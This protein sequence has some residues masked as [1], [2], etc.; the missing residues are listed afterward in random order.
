[1][2]FQ[3]E[4]ALQIYIDESLD[5]LADFEHDL[6]LMEQ[7]GSELD[8][9]IINKVF[10]GAHSIKGGA[11]LL[12]FKNIK[13]LA[14]K[15]ENLLGMI[16]DHAVE[17]HSAIINVLLQAAD[18]LKDL[19]EDS[20]H[21]DDKDISNHL[22]ALIAFCEVQPS[23][24]TLT[25]QT[26]HRSP[27]QPKLQIPGKE[28]TGKDTETIR[29]YIDESL[30]HLDEI[31]SDILT[32]EQAGADIDEDLVNKVF[33][34]AHSIK[35]GAGFLGF[36]NIKK[37]AHKIESLLG[38][39]RSRELAVNAEIINALLKG[40][41]SLRNLINNITASDDIDI[42]LELQTLSVFNTEDRQTAAQPG[43]PDLQHQ[44]PV[45]TTDREEESAPQQNGM[46]VAPSA[47]TLRV[48][49]RL[50]DSLMTLAGEL[51]LSRN[52]LLQATV[53]GDVQHIDTIGQNINMI[54]SEL[55]EAIMHTRLQPIGNIF[56]KFPRL[57][58]DLAKEVDK[59]VQLILA[60]ED[61]ELDKTII[62][63][64]SD[65]LTHLV[66]NSIDHGIEPPDERRAKNKPAKGT[67]ILSA[68]HEAG[69]V[70]LQIK[71]DGQGLNGEAFVQKAIDTGLLRSDQARA[72]SAKE[73][74]NLILQPGFSMAKTVTD[75]SG[76]GVGMDVVK[77]N[78]EKLGGQI[79]INSK[80]GKGTTINI[81][82]PL[83][84]AIIS[85]QLIRNN[86]ERYAIPQVNLVELLRIPANQ[87]KNRIERVGSADVVR[88]RDH[89][90]PLVRLTAV[91]GTDDLYFDPE[92]C[93][94]KRNRRTKL[95]DRRSKT[96]PLF[97]T[98]HDSQAE[99]GVINH[100]KR[101]RSDRRIHAASALNI[102]IVSNG[103]MKYGL[104]VDQLL[105]SEEIVVKPLGQHLK[106]CTIY[107]GATILGDGRISLILDVANIAVAAGLT[108][109]D[110]SDRAHEITR[111]TASDAIA[112]RERQALLV[113]R[114]NTEE[115]FAVPLN[116]V[117][118]IEKIKKSQIEEIGGKRV[119]QYRG[120]TLMLFSIDQAVQVRPIADQEDLLVLIFSLAGH[121]VGLLA[122]GPVNS[123]EL[124]FDIDDRTH[125]Q[126]GVMGSTLIDGRIT[127][128]INIYDIFQSLNPDWFEKRSA[129]T[130]PDGKGITI[131][132]VEDSNFFRNQVKG[133]LAAENYKVLEA[134]DGLVA[135]DLLAKHI[136]TISLVVTDIEMPNLDG[137]GLTE[138]IKSRKEYCHLPV[139]A[140]TSLAGETDIDRGREV[141]FDK[142]L[143]KLDKENLLVTVHELVNKQS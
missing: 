14:H 130:T 42:S 1:M 142:Y 58:R 103:I 43:A 75:I 25:T 104:V 108:S 102:I 87:I 67:I 136:D 37:L 4:E 19:I 40:T 113:F 68:A 138:E 63:A 123:L 90:L 5:H 82:L 32:I 127:L 118:R 62:E 56:S 88:L 101:T 140:L 17:P 128:F 9:K 94:M 119:I 47:T 33:R 95:A 26:A 39:I 125:K 86:G 57:V 134:E 70:L 74:L 81:K 109:V 54:T 93:I 79:D 34:G 10:R 131:L 13:E 21:S 27:S 71:D 110:E 77:T 60:G 89:L 69:S 16:R 48:K 55:Q 96:S 111:K 49:T 8:E 117:I 126:F 2:R 45:A 85:S 22:Q 7:Q 50:L 98:N 51:V 59:D 61:V 65:P 84:L 36:T 6:L 99:N 100:P 83:T 105:D 139:I 137:F 46:H 133:F 78:F 135:L 28:E 12:G 129:P 44:P 141:G 35:G 132:I 23:P 112:E 52:Q 121:E 18:V 24:D 106:S 92:S 122:T 53:A 124:S 66:R 107:A 15:T 73:K 143:I 3:A 72:M 11:G 20:A 115:Q 64:I 31:E 114:S 116:Q 76:R 80:L 30:E 97:K 29:V 91:L 41:D 38:L 120:A